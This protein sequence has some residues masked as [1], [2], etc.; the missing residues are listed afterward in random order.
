MLDRIRYG[1][2]SIV[3]M[4]AVSCGPAPAGDWPIWRGNAGHTASTPDALPVEMHLQWVREL[5]PLR[6]AWP[7]SQTKLRFDDVHEPIVLGNRLFVASNAND[8]VTAYS[9]KT[10]EELWRFYTQGPLRFAPV[11]GN[12]RVYVGGDDGYLYCLSAADGSLAWKVR[13]GPSDRPIIGNDRLIS[14][15][16]IRGGA[17]L[18]DGTVYFAAGIWPSM[19]IFIHAVDAETGEIVWT[20]NTTGSQFV[21]HPHGAS[22]Y[23]SVV[24]QGYLAIS[25]DALL[26]PG[27]RSLPAV[28]DRKTGTMRNYEFGGKSSGGYDVIA[29]EDAYLVRGELLRLKDSASYAR[30]AGT[31]LDGKLLY[32]S[33]NRPGS[34]DVTST[35]GEIKEVKYKDR[36]D[37]ER[38]RIDFIASQKWQIG[39]EQSGSGKVFLKAGDV[40]YTADEARIAAYDSKPED[41]PNGPRKALWN[42]EIDASVATMIAADERLFVV[43]DTGSLFCF[44]EGKREPT[45][46]REVDRPLTAT[47][48]E[49]SRRASELLT[50]DGTNEGYAISW[51]IGSGRLIEEMLA[52]TKLHL[53][54]VDP[55]SARVEKQRRRLD[56]AGLY[57]KR[58]AIHVG[59]MTTFTPP[60]YLANVVFCEDPASVGFDHSAPLL[61]KLYDSLRPYGGTC[62]LNI[63]AS[64]QKAFERSAVGA[65]LR[66]AEV[67][68]VGD[69]AT[70]TRAGSLPES[71]NWTHQYGDSV[72]SLISQDRLVKVPLGVL[73]FGGPSNDKVLP[74]HGHGPSPQVAG[75][76]L[77]IEGP[78]MLR[79]VDVYTGRVLWEKELAGLGKYYD[80]TSHF[81]GANEIGSNYV[82]LPDVVYVVYGSRL[83]ELDSATGDVKREFRLEAGSDG[84]PPQWGFACANDDVLV[85]TSSPVKVEQSKPK[86]ETVNIPKGM[87]AIIKPNAEWRYLAG[88]DP[89]GAWSSVEFDAKDWKEGA[90]GFGF[91]DSDDKTVLRAMR[92]KYQRVYI[93]NSFE[94]GELEDATALSL[95]INF[96]DAFIAYLNGNEFARANVGN[97]SGADASRIS[98][99][100]ASGHEV[101]EIKDF[102]KQLRPGN[103]VI[104]I[105][106]HNQNRV[107]GDFSLDPYIIAGKPDTTLAVSSEDSQERAEIGDSLLPAQYASA[108]RRLKVFDR[109]TGE[110]LW[111][112]DAAFNF[113][114]NGIILTDDIVYCIDGMSPAKL[115]LLKRRGIDAT[116]KTQLLALDAHTGDVKWSTNEDVFG[117]FLSYSIEHDVLLQGGSASRDRARDE[118]A[119]GLVA[120][121]GSTG[122]ILWKKLKLAY[123]GPCLLWRDKIITNGAG[124]YQMDLFTGEKTGWSYSR[125]YGCNTAIGSENLLTFR[126][127]AAGF[128]DLAGDSG[129]GNIGGFRSS[130]TSNLIAADG[131]LSAPDYTRTCSCAYQNQTSLA[132]IHMPD[133]E[134][135]TFNRTVNSDEEKPD[136]IGINFGA[137][138]DRRSDE[139]TLWYEYPTIGGPSPSLGLSVKADEPEW[140]TRHSSELTTSEHNWVAASGGKGITSIELPLADNLRKANS[141]TVRLYF[142]EPN[143][144][145]PGERVFSVAIQGNS[146]LSDFD[147]VRAATPP[148]ACVV[149]EFTGIDVSS[150]LRIDLESADASGSHKPLLCG[151]EVIS[152]N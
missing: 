96:D 130:C 77:F 126:S 124:G 115:A 94:R 145:E 150:G 106:G 88:S 71:G 64:E 66:K 136:R 59:D 152:E 52:R 44:G 25:G 2:L 57:G 119:K 133:V 112:R 122:E 144:L 43:T 33:S 90:A 113:R 1:W 83:L 30:V 35:S 147:I 104:A 103:N 16:P 56:A 151:I 51:G 78:D 138:G 149:Q 12:D 127:G 27:G 82:S 22:S 60:P 31:V 120:Y 40:L 34:I 125:M 29:G 79:S 8:R 11:V 137:P 47:S 70:L 92:G 3:F 107:D 123:S 37:R 75:G 72:N 97:S 74:R 140:F 6:P 13:G 62:C 143:A 132:L 135:W 21:V 84:K 65:S 67:G 20:N 68:R 41:K 17:V 32:A 28:L 26:V 93:R 121:R 102:Q 141:Y 10:G 98:K 42:V 19:G 4:A 5:A 23:G 49:W 146:V 48:D 95:V 131:V 111:S 118:S 36:K 89:E 108:S 114:H 50:I 105:E 53:V 116:G 109:Q 101:F 117:T 86:P 87:R 80:V 69:F 55:D 134:L 58:V 142:A 85:A 129:T 15:W 54:V 73:W 24:P 9:T 139:G 76:R 7:E 61:K 39:I 14:T 18:A 91:G 99:H 110:E 38:T 63:S 81:P 46:H 45:R 100:E 128:C 148:G